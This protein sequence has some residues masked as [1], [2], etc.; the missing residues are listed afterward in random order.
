MKR[1]FIIFVIGFISLVHLNADEVN[2][3]SEKSGIFVGIDIGFALNSISGSASVKNIFDSTYSE[4]TVAGY[5]AN[6]DGNYGLRV[7]YQHFFGAHNGLRFYGHFN[8][9]DFSGYSVMQYGGNVDYLLNF[10]DKPGAWG[11]FLGAGYEWTS[12]NFAKFLKD[13]S[14]TVEGQTME[15]SLNGVFMNIG[16]SKTVRNKNRF[17]FGVKVPFYT[18]YKTEYTILG[19]EAKMTLK[20]SS[21][22]YLA[23]TYTF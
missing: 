5:R 9:N 11:L 15:K 12:G 23:Y 18:Y 20:K 7:G 14:P 21:V 16:L 2:N 22:I 19:A 8:Y 13:T 6:F 10:S 1:F 17:E 3:S 4:Q